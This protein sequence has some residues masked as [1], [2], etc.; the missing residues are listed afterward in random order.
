MGN[1]RELQEVYAGIVVTDL[2]G[3]I[4]L[5]TPRVASLCGRDRAEVE[6]SAVADLISPDALGAE[7]QGRSPFRIGHENAVDAE[8]TL[9]IGETVKLRVRYEPAR[10]VDTTVGA[11]Y[12]VTQLV[13]RKRARV[14]AA[15]CF[16]QPCAI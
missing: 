2:G 15:A 16:P 14:P 7:S 10:R 11:R 4:Q 13:E 8:V 5:C 1:M 6:G 3:R 12:T 9:A